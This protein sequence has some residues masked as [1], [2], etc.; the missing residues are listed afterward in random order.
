MAFPIPGDAIEPHLNLNQY[1][2]DS[3]A[4]TFFFRVGGNH[5]RCQT[6]TQEVQPGDLLIVNRA[7]DVG[8][9]S[10]IVGIINGEFI[11][12]RVQKRAGKWVPLTREDDNAELSLTI[13]GV[14]IVIVR[15]VSAA[16]PCLA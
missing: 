6:G 2:I 13:W 4:S 8:H 1:L 3:P 15:N 5:K 10:L 7:L 9:Q 16:P 11:V 12:S 14:V